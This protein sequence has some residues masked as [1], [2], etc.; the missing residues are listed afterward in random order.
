MLHSHSLT[1]TT[2]KQLVLHQQAISPLSY[3]PFVLLLTTV[4]FIFK[5]CFLSCIDTKNSVEMQTFPL[6]LPKNGQ[7]SECEITTFTRVTNCISVNNTISEC[8]HHF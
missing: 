6:K 4:I 8:E 1:I 2:V 5:V 3:C 7:I